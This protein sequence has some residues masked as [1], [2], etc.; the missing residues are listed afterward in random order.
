MVLSTEAPGGAPIVLRREAAVSRS[1]LSHRQRYWKLTRWKVY[2]PF[3]DPHL[4]AGISIAKID[5]GHSQHLM[6]TILKVS[7]C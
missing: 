4:V 6:N 3:I 1:H 2:H 7:G 5:K